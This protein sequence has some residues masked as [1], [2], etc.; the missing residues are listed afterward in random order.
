MSAIVPGPYTEK[1]RFNRELYLIPLDKDTSKTYV[2]QSTHQGHPIP[3]P[4]GRAM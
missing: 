2:T 1:L 4:H 3:G